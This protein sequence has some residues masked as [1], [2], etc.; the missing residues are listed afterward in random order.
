MGTV[1]IREL[2]G[3]VCVVDAGN[4]SGGAVGL[5]VVLLN[6]QDE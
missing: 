4:E 1:D 6:V 2:L 3:L 5:C